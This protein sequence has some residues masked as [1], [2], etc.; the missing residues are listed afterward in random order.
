ML[1]EWN[2]EHRKKFSN[3]TI[4][5]GHKLVETGLFT[6][7][8]LIKLLERQP[9]DQMDVCSMTNNPD[10]SY[11]NAFIT[12]DFRGVPADVL[13]AAAKAGRIFINLRKAMNIHPEYRVLLNE[14]FG[15][16]SEKTGFSGF[17]PKGGI[18]ISS[19][20]SQTPYHFDKTE[21]ILWHI[22][23]K[24]RI[25]IYPKTQDFIADED[26]ENVALSHRIDDLPYDQ[27]FD[28]AAGIYDL[29]PGQAISWPLNAPHRV[30]N[31]S[32]CVSVTTEYSTR[33]CVIKN[34]N[35]I[36]NAALRRQLGL[37]PRFD[38]DGQIK[39]Y[40]K[41]GLGMALRKAGYIDRNDSPDMVEFSIDPNVEGFVVPITPFTRNF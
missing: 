3:E 10:P 11:P 20:I 36:A 13:L 29:K 33:E 38:R 15:D 41:F 34:N 24:K 7:K 39:R 25:Y 9:V 16:L 18:L 5:F 35:M 31:G 17:K 4:L 2:E 19:P 1:S 26:Y 32:F 6:D 12:G 40:A 14:M 28:Q 23:G 8:S 22:R 21:T 37:S 30:D 27:S